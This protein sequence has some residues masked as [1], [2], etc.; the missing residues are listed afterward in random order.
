MSLERGPAN[1][2]ETGPAVPSNGGEK[3][4]ALSRDE[5][6]DIL[7]NQRRR[8]ALHFLK[9]RNGDGTEL[10]ELSTQVAA[11]ENGKSAERVTS[12]ERRRVYTSL[13]QFHLPKLDRN[14]IVEY[15][16]RRGSVE[17][18]GEATDLDVYL[19]VVEESDVPW[20][21]YYLGLSGLSLALFGVVS[22]EIYPLTLVPALAWGVLVALVFTVSAL[23]HTYHD[24]R[25]RLGA[26]GPPA[27][28]REP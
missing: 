22:V 2:T 13:Q 12:D 1:G 28:L 3:P 9:Q 24:R 11:W 17:L 4:S 10:R 7:S 8:H 14:G 20:S 6:F 15:D 26:D 16:D 27:D 5:V 18:A 23:A 19:D 21:Q 25:M